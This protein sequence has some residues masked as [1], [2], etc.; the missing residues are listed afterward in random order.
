MSPAHSWHLTVVNRNKKTLTGSSY[1]MI[2]SSCDGITRQTSPTRPCY[3]T[4]LPL[5]FDC[6]VSLMAPLPQAAAMQDTTRVTPLW[7]SA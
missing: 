7:R 3:I 6:M 5:M 4:S 2:A 1:L